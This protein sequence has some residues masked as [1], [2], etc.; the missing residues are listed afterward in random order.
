MNGHLEGQ[1]EVGG[2]LTIGAGGTANANIKASDL[3]VAGS[4]KGNVETIGRLVLRAGASLEGDVKAAGI[5]IEDGANFKGEVDIAR[6][7]SS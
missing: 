4:A 6:P 5:V 3:I 2:R 1:M 7:P